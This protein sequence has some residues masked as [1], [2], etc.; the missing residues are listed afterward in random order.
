M[1]KQIIF[2]ALVSLQLQYVAAQSWQAKQ[3]GLAARHGIIDISAPDG[4][5]AYAMAYDADDYYGVNLHEITLTHNGGNSWKAQAISLLD[6]VRII[7]LGAASGY[8]IHVIAWNP[9]SSAT[10]PGGKVVRSRDGGNTW[11]QEAANAFTDAASFP[12]DIAFL[13]AFDGVMFGDPVGGAF[14]IYTTVNGGNTWTKVA[15]SNIPAPI[16]TANQSEY[17]SPYI[18][19]KFGNSFVTLTYVYDN[20]TNTIP[21]GRLLQSDDKGKTWYVKNAYVPF[22]NTDLTLKFR[23]KNV[24]LLKY[25]GKLFRTTDGGTTWTQ[26]NFTGRYCQYDLDNIPGKDGWWVSTGGEIGIGGITSKYG[27]SISYDDGN[28]WKIIDTTMSHTCVEMT[29]FSHGYSGGISTDSKGKDGVYV[30]S[31]T[32]FF[33]SAQE[34]STE[35]TQAISTNTEASQVVL[36]VYPNPS[37]ESFSLALNSPQARL[38]LIRVINIEGVVV[39]SERVVP[40]GTTSFGANLAAGIY[41]AEVIIDGNKTTI[42][43]VKQ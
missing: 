1:K 39:L 31:S 27:S 38:A 14:E 24:G 40:V 37:S 28:T 23:N 20:S 5:N 3:S 10:S 32:K 41:T 11:K 13:N 43:I 19:E 16:A 9:A 15:A 25:D 8:D 21:Y 34:E 36:N 4:S 17:G 35:E 18:M 6:G 33:K 22:T 30:Y 7:G 26:V 2:A 12:D 42:Q 29:D